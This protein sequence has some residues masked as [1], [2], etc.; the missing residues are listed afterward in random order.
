MSGYREKEARL[1][2]LE[3]DAIIALSKR[4]KRLRSRVAL[5]FAVASLSVCW[6]GMAAHATGYWAP[7]GRAPDGSYLVSGITLLIAGSVSAA[8]FV[9]PGFLVYVGLRARLRRSWREEQRAK[10][11]AS[12]YLEENVTRFG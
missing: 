11:V 1:D 12:S 5:P 8:P 4:I 9:I 3:T 10:G 6:L 2:D 7:L